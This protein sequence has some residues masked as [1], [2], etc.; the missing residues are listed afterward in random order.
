MATA[1]RIT[2]DTV[3]AFRADTGLSQSEAA[4]ALGTSKKTIYNWE[5]RGSEPLPENAAIRFAGGVRR[6]AATFDTG[7]MLSANLAEAV[8]LNLADPGPR[9]TYRD[10][11]LKRTLEEWLHRETSR[12]GAPREQVS[13]YLRIVQLASDALDFAEL[14]NRMGVNPGTVGEIAA[15]VVDVLI[16]SGAYNVYGRSVETSGEMLA[17]VARGSQMARNAID[18]SRARRGE[19]VDHAGL[20]QG[21]YLLGARDDD[22]DLEAE[23]QQEEP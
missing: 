20:S 16:D 13:N 19:S 9:S 4:D 3:R 7:R 23:A 12:Y 15:G 11:A 5:A 2:G 10:D 21:D 6:W 1:H 17:L 22:D 14:A 18:A 8:E